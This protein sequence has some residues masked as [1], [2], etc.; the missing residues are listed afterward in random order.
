MKSL[1]S[2]F[3]LQVCSTHSLKYSF[4][5]W[6]SVS[7]S[8]RLWAP[9]S[10]A[11]KS[12]NCVLPTNHTLSNGQIVSAASRHVTRLVSTLSRPPDV[13]TPR[14]RRFHFGNL[15]AHQLTSTF[16]RF[17]APLPAVWI[18][19]ASFLS[20]YTCPRATSRVYTTLGVQVPLQRGFSSLCLTCTFR[21]FRSIPISS[22]TTRVDTL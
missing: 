11:L 12:L 8:F 17:I 16:R 4:S 19:P 18:S 14:N 13:C 15:P 3:G 9:A 5:L 7:Y 10:S 20:I 2:H 6:T 22:A 1:V 21:T